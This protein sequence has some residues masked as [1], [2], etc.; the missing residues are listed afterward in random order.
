[1]WNENEIVGVESFVQ[2]TGN[3]NENENE[4]EKPEPETLM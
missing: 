1:M 4:N 2:K 3:E